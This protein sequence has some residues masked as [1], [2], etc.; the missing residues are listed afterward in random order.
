[1]AVLRQQTLLFFL[2]KIFFLCSVFLLPRVNSVSFTFNAFNPNTGGIS[3]Q[4]DAFSSS[5]VLQL[6]RNQIDNNLTYSAGR[7]SYIRPVHIWDANTGQLTDF[8]TRFSFIA[9]DVRD[10]TIYGDGL[11]FFLAP[12]DSEIPPNAV[13]G[14]LALFSPENALNVSKANQIVAVEFDSYSNAWDPGYDHVGINVNSIVSVAEVSWKSNIYN[15]EVVNAWVSYDSVSKNMSVFVSDTQNPVFRGIY[16]F[17]YN[18][19]L[20]DVLPE[21][22]RIG[23]SASTGTAVETNSILSWEFYSTL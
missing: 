11:T 7:A 22:A 14:Y 19:D 2:T 16:S 10:S 23:F 1:M 21:W 15:G 12:V 3:F 6:S 4:G 5:G 18:V 20:R 8:T 17:S 13:G 9:K